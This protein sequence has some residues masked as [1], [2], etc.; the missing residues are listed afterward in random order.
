MAKLEYFVEKIK[1]KSTSDKVLAFAAPYTNDFINAA[2]QAIDHGVIQKVLLIGELNKIKEAIATSNFEDDKFTIIEAT[3][4][5][6]VAVKTMTLASNDEVNIVMKGLID[7]SILLG[8][9]LKPEYGLRTDKHMAHVGLLYSE[10]HD[11]YYIASDAG[12]NI[13]PDVNQKKVIIEHCVELA[14]KLGKDKPYV[15]MLTAKEKVYDKMQATVDAAALQEMNEKGEITGCVVSGPLQIDNAVSERCAKIKG[16]TDPVS[17]KADILIMPNIEAGNIFAK[18]LWLLGGWE[19]TGYVAG[20][21]I[22][23]GVSSRS[24]TEKGLLGT[25]IIAAASAE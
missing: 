13:V 16:V 22:P 7:T 2:G 8:E 21:K 6:D 9:L 19:I 10:N 24:D 5:K 15:A 3:D 18:A 23:V 25:I 17:G 11:Q 20:A 14:H 1:G 12:M 4:L